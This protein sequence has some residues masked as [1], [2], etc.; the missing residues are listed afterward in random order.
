[1]EK[2]IAGIFMVSVLV[3]VLISI[4]GINHSMIAYDNTDNRTEKKR[5]NLSLYT[6][7]GT[8]NQYLGTWISGII[9]RIDASGKQV[10]IYSN[11]VQER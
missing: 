7:Y 5:S 8:G 11:P 1:M 9:P 6:D 10:N 4:Y 3:L 2:I